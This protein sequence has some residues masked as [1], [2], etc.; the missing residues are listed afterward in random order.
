MVFIILYFSAT[1]N[2]AYVAK[3]LSELLDYKTLNLLEKIK[4]KDYTEVYSDKPFVICAPTYVCEMPQFVM[5]FLKKT[6]LT[7]N[8]D[9]YFILTSGGYAGIS[10]ILGSRIIKKKGLTFKGYSE[11]KMPR[12]Y[13]ASNSYP[14]L[15]QDEIEKRIRDTS[16]SLPDIASTIRSGGVLKSRHVW[17]FE[18][19]V[20]IPFAPLWHKFRQPVK[21]F[22]VTDRCIS[23]GLCSRLCPLNLI[24]LD[25]GKPTWNGERCSHCMSCI[26]N[27]PVEAIEYG[28]IT[29][30]KK[31]YQ[32]RKYQYAANG[33]HDK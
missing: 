26:Q 23:C 33:K 7:G 18:K 3:T 27:C 29:K 12:N 16:N 11:L 1:G 20:T 28:T 17:L 10:G 24:K 13:I 14:E 5:N 6:P 21:D 19:A 31:R 2:T 8:R 9:V 30:D 15:S 22:F 25:N 4:K 32:F